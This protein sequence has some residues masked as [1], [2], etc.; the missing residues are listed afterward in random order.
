[1]VAPACCPGRELAKR[2]AEDEGLGLGGGANRMPMAPTAAFFADAARLP[3][4]ADAQ[5]I[6]SLFR[7]EISRP[8]SIARR[9]SAM[10][11]IVSEQVEA[12]R[13]SIY[14]ERVLAKHP[15][16]GVRLRN[17]TAI[18]LMHGPVTVY[19][20]AGYRGDARIEDLPAGG[21]RLLSYAVDLDMEV[22]ARSEPRPEQLVSVR[23][24]QGTLVATRRLAR[25]R[26]L[27]IRN[28]GA[29]PAK[30][31][32][33]HAI[34]PGW[35]LVTPA[36]ADETTRDRH[37]FAVVV[38][39]GQPAALVIDEELPQEQV[40]A[41]TNLDDPSIVLFERAG[42]S[43]PKVK[44]A[45]VE[46]L[47]QRR[48]LQAIAEERARREREI[49]AIGQEQARIRENMTRLERTS[50]LFTRYVQKLTEQEGRIESL[51][52]EIAE[53]T[54]EEQTLRRAFD[55]F[56]AGLGAE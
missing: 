16:A 8:V 12:E 21:E 2:T 15:L 27:E 6:G 4:L 26:R 11:P 13:V 19:D 29:A 52:R 34:E 22:A 37:R 32:V 33:E 20:A 39:P 17:S 23:L 5:A 49:E 14:D 43:S 28:S 36:K 45:L 25:S 56:V 40:V 50:E 44:A 18:D 1:M 35:T 47:R 41:V 7:Y 48:A 9:Q 54:G 51:R 10:L 42:A 24:V 55:E 53:R 31:L 3:G 30:L 46:V 38:P